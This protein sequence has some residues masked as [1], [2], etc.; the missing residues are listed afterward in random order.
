MIPPPATP[1]TRRN[2]CSEPHD[3]AKDTAPIRLLPSR[4]GPF[5]GKVLPPA[6]KLQ[7]AQ[8]DISDSPTRS[9]ASG[10]HPRRASLAI[11]DDARRSAP[12]HGPCRP[13]AASS[14]RVRHGHRQPP[15]NILHFNKLGPTKHYDECRSAVATTTVIR[16]L[17]RHQPPARNH[18][19]GVLG[20]V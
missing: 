15:T 6:G 1:Q 10:R 4:Y 9:G 11:A 12:P 2:E 16:F 14:R 13:L 17:Y 19:P 7:S 20:R 3:V 18:I 5:E 8:T